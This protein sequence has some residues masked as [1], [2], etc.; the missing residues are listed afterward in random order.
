MDL[1]VSF[2][3]RASLSRGVE[4]CCQAAAEDLQPRHDSKTPQ[5]D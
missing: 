1:L 4:R 3:G 2:E 5:P